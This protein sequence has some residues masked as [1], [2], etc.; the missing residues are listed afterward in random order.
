MN[1]NVSY[2]ISLTSVLKLVG[3]VMT[4]VDLFNGVVDKIETSMSELQSNI[5]GNDVLSRLTA[6]SNALDK[7][8]NQ[9]CSSM[10][11]LS[12]FMFQQANSYNQAHFGTGGGLSNIAN[13]INSTYG[14][15]TP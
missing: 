15:T 13:Q 2:D 14:S 1:N 11:N 7:I 5:T 8:S 3:D 12:A 9:L 10:S 4:Q 6:I